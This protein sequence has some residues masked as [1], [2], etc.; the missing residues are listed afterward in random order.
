VRKQ[1]P[2]TL[3]LELTETTPAFYVR[4]S[5]QAFWL[6][7]IDG[8]LLERAAKPPKGLIVLE[9]AALKKPQA[10]LHAAWSTP[11]L[12]AEAVARLLKA[13]ET[14]PQLR[15]KITALNATVSAAPEAV[16]EGRIR[17][18]FGTAL[19]DES[20][21]TLQMRVAAETLQKLNAQNQNQRGVLDLSTAGKA[22][23]TQDWSKALQ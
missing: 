23:F 18:R 1:P 11:Q 19:E 14:Q 15:K 9:G 5:P 8:K 3:R 6:L 16:Y 20:T 13:L 2:G 7:D 22:Y 4:E 17:L 10:G 21:L 12:Q